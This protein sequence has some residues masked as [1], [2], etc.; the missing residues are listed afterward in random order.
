MSP[1]ALPQFLDE[2]D[3]SAVNKTANNFADHI[4][5]NFDKIADILLEYE[6]YE[7][8]KDEYDRTMDLL[9]SLP[10][11]KD[12]F[13]RRINEVA[14][15]LPRNQPLY[16]FSCF[17]VVPSLMAKSVHFRIP[18]SMKG[19]FPRLLEVLDI[20]KFF[21]NI[22]VSK[23]E[24][25]D[26]LQERT[27]LL[28]DPATKEAVPQTDAVIFTGTTLHAEKLRN[29]FDLRTLFISNGSGHNPI[30]VSKNAKVS[31][32]VEA[33]LKLQ[34]Y[35]Q[36]QD[37]AAPNS[38][39]VHADVHNSFLKLLKKKLK[40]IKIGPYRNHRC[41]VGPISEPEDLKRIEVL[42]VD[43]LKWLD[44]STR[45][46]IRTAEAIVEPTIICKD[47]KDG[48]NFTEVFA[49]IFFIQ[50]YEQDADLKL[51]FEDKHYS[52]NAMYVTLYG[53]SEYIMRLIGRE[54]GGKILHFN[55]TYLHNNHLH[56]KG[57]ERGTQ[58]YGGYGYGA[59]S[60]AI[61]GVV[62]AK[63]T[64]PQRDIYEQLVKPIIEVGLVEEK[65]KS[66]LKMTEVTTKN[67]SKLMGLKLNGH[68]ESNGTMTAKS[69]LDFNGTK[70]GD[71][72]YVELDPRQIFSL[73]D[74]QNA[75]AISR[76]EIED[77][78]QVK[79][80]REFLVKNKDP[81][82][83]EFTAHLYSISKQA[84]LSEEKNK[85][86]QLRFFRNIYKLLFGK[87]NGPRLAHF[88]LDADRDK[89]CELLNV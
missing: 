28:V 10:E 54:I 23:K 70:I 52:K 43:H 65:K 32:A 83:D 19:F 13:V 15:F 35:N 31:D 84:D 63:P 47:L 26:F 56:F 49:P 62:T 5:T 68:I 1:K 7:V 36:G 37:C 89:I 14:A 85:E 24:R 74:Y 87:E 78:E 20:D 80:L 77:Q 57:V 40:R 69:Y 86:R 88:L 55:D 79:Q 27:A 76:L 39:L 4:E 21:P 6:S 17:V 41:K 34:L 66:L 30:V 71:K 38:I 12:Y 81:D 51:Y 11:N 60:I 16:A 58:P 67:V 64:C 45:G 53:E 25:L 48:G 61:G 50:K 3:F 72:R 75:E 33:A 73:Q 18:Q 9:R 29:I 44:E 46:V 59:S 82:L 8:V 42:L 22:V 2:I